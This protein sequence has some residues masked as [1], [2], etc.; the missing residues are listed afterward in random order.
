MRGGHL[1]PTY[2]VPRFA[3]RSMVT[4]SFPGTIWTSDSSTDEA[5]SVALFQNTHRSSKARH[6]FNLSQNTNENRT[7]PLALAA[8]RL[9]VAQRHGA[10]GLAHHRDGDA[11]QTTQLD[12]RLGHVREPAVQ[13]EYN[14]ALGQ[15][16]GLNFDTEPLRRVSLETLEVSE[17]SNATRT[18]VSQALQNHCSIVPKSR[19]TEGNSR[20]L[21][22]SRVWQKRKA[23]TI[24]TAPLDAA[25]RRFH[26]HDVHRLGVL[27]LVREL[28][29]RV[30][31][32]GGAHRA[33]QPQR[34]VVA[35]KSVRKVFEIHLVPRG[36]SH[37]KRTSPHR[38]HLSCARR[39]APRH[40]QDEDYHL[41]RTRLFL[42]AGQADAIGYS[43]ALG[44]WISSVLPSPKPHS[45]RSRAAATL[46]RKQHE[47][48]AH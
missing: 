47:T 41:I 34:R 23:N 36:R 24:D 12:S 5:R 32:V 10:R 40:A 28:A 38:P 13:R 18:R 37:T 21:R 20:D 8:C 11:R 46:E 3:F 48:R 30:H 6:L 1:T 14:I 39:S 25:E 31:D 4:R 16:S 22:Y 42:R 27:D 2:T 35:E 43:G 17:S 15:N 9:L 44:E 7:S 29:R 45:S 33:T 26:G 19:E